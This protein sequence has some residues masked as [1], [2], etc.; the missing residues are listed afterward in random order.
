MITKESDQTE[1]RVNDLVMPRF[2]GWYLVEVTGL[3]HQPDSG[4]AVDYCR[5]AAES[6][7]GGMEW[8]GNSQH[9]VVAW[10][11]LPNRKRCACGSPSAFNDKTKN[12]CGCCDNCMPF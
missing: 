2:P 5:A 10:Y 12:F 11:E 1:L 8:V 4:F 7:G 6:D 3:I 9:N